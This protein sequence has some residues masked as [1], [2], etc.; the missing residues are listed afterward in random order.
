MLP[1]RRKGRAGPV[2]V[3]LCENKMSSPV[4]RKPARRQLA[5]RCV[6]AESRIKLPRRFLG[7]KGKARGNLVVQKG[8]LRPEGHGEL[9]R[10]S[11]KPGAWPGSLDERVWTEQSLHL[12]KDPPLT[13][14]TLPW[15]L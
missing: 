6:L 2:R 9:G 8:K 12:A 4:P 3:L 10:V 15:S 1:M 5:S 13:M 7:H 11:G 14:Q